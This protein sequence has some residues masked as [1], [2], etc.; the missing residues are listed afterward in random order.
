MKS[1]EDSPPAQPPAPP[2]A[3]ESREDPATRYGATPPADAG[4]TAYSAVPP[5]PADDGGTR[6]PDQAA[7][8]GLTN[9]QLQGT[10]GDPNATRY[11]EEGTDSD[12][13][14]HTP[15]DSPTASL[16]GWRLSLRFGGYEVLE[17]ISHGGMGVVFK[18]RQQ[19]PERLVA[20]KMIR[21]GE[22][23]SEADVR[24]F[25]QEAQE[26]AR[27]DHP[28][29][30][31]IYEVGEHQGLHFFSM[32]LFEGGSLNQHLDR[33][34]HDRKAAAQ[35]VATVARA[36]HH[37]HQR[38]LLHRDLKPGNILLDAEGQPHVAD[39]GLAK[40]LKGAGEATPTDCVGTPEYMAPEQ[41]RGEARLT[42]AVDVYAL[43][44]ILYALL[45][46]RPPFRGASNWDTID[47]VLHR[48]PLPP[49]KDSPGC[50]RD[51]EKICLKCLHKEP[52]RRYGSAEAV[53]EDLERFLAG[54][55]VQ[56]RPVRAWER[57]WMWAKRRPAL[58]TTYLLLLLV[59]GLGAGGGIALGLWRQTEN[60]RQQADEA[61]Q[62]LA[63]Q[64]QLVE[65][66][67]ESERKAKE[68]L[69]RLSYF[70]KINLAHREWTDN[71]IDRAKQLLA[72]CEEKR[73]EWE[74]HYVHR[75]CHSDLRTLKGHTKEVT[76]V[77]YSPDGKQVASSSDDGTIK[78][79]DAV[80][81]RVIFSLSGS[82]DRIREVAYSPDGERL[83]GAAQ[84]GTVKVWDVRQPENP[85][86]ELVGNAGPA[87]DVAFSPDG[88]KLAST[89]D[90]G[91]IVWD[92]RSGKQCW[93]GQEHAGTVRTAAFSPDSKQLATG[94][95][96]ET[97]VLWEVAS[98]RPLLRPFQ[99]HK[100]WVLSVAFSPDGRRLASA[101]QDE[102]VI[103]WDTATGESVQTLRGHSGLVWRAVFSPDRN[104]P[105]ELA[106][107]SRDGTVILWDLRT[108]RPTRTI[109]GHSDGV[110]G[111]DYSPD[112]RYLVSG[113]WDRTL[114][115][116]DAHTSPEAR[117]FRHANPVLGVAFNPPDG[118]H[119]V[120]ASSDKVV[121]LWD[122]AGGK[123]VHDFHGNAGVVLGIAFSPDGKWLVGGSSHHVV[124]R[125]PAW[126]RNPAAEAETAALAANALFLAAQGLSGQALGA[127]PAPY[128]L[129]AAG[130]VHSDSGWV[131]VW[132]RE[133]RR[134]ILALKA[135]DG[136]VTHVAFCPDGTHFAT[137][138][139]DQHVKVWHAQ[140]GRKV[141][142]CEHA[143]PVHAVAFSPQTPHL[144]SGSQDSTVTVWDAN[145]GR[146]LFDLN[147]HE[148]PIYCVAFSPDGKYLASA[149]WDGTIKIW[150]VANRRE[151]STLHGHT[152][153]VNA[154][155]FSPNG[156]RLASASGDGLVKLWD[157][158][159]GQEVLSLKGHTDVV[160]AIAFSPCGRR[161]ASAGL[162]KTV[163]VWETSAG[164][165]TR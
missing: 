122:V 157:V 123:E 1:P 10:P 59:L 112:G 82:A 131:K 5:P 44:G 103:V 13:I 24:R 150:E 161:L 110:T 119:L 74:W 3:S 115:I 55:P 92:S 57:T 51:L 109:K 26:A 35:L 37:A 68:E 43:G 100:G 79:W 90:R 124:V 15:S 52:E 158:E 154:V 67:L 97:V 2:A 117:V 155:A 146:K 65:V 135:H 118:Q 76:C 60:E 4:A 102:T 64:E 32:K 101:S 88:S 19:E 107:A 132:D 86:L 29:I 16:S 127:G 87:W 89:H 96:D 141:F 91:V 14:A 137:A 41:T 162:D 145:T 27:L 129:E 31:P 21:S 63:A 156:R 136:G 78:V 48:D 163:I 9:Y 73:R 165:S 160:S 77:V 126:M 17:E 58:A 104:R 144:A 54:K 134:L 105:E 94:S 151:V 61:R 125:L 47:Q 84:D 113:S 106:S 71:N 8:P 83:A 62:Q 7:N 53:A 138:S 159:T 85:P 28:N 72:G 139:E 70:H 140:T 36:V 143:S 12:A 130:A 11:T 40:R 98:G 69:A 128:A 152:G 81:G 142:H 95:E 99:K 42:T 23:A 18:A 34:R 80:T 148:Y 20:L 50:P 114:K 149:S 33:Y 56:A 116:W 25:R 153:P 49:S 111:V 147:G 66:A 93:I 46:G 75:L 121:K 120:S 38:Q 133:T 30:V 45:T 39:F 6:Y 108:G 164:Q 22:L